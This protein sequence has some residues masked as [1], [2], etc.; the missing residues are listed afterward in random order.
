VPDA[1]PT[2]PGDSAGEFPARVMSSDDI[3]PGKGYLTD[4]AIGWLTYLDRKT[5]FDDS[6]FKD[7]SVHPSWDN[8]T[9]APIGVYHRYDL[10]YATY[11][12]GLMAENTP[13]WR[14]EYGKVLGYM[15]DRFLE[16]WAMWDW[17]ENSGPDPNRAN[18]PAEA[19]VLFPPGYMG[20]YDIPGWAGNGIEPYQYDPDPVRG[21]GACNLMY[22]G[23]LNLVIS[24]FNYVT[25]DSKYDTDFKV[26]YDKDTV[27]TYNHRSLNE[28]IA[29][30][31]RAN[32]TGLGCE[33][34]KIYPWCNNLTG[35]ASRFYDVMHGTNMSS[36]YE[37]WKRWYRENAM[38]P[39]YG[40]EPVDKH[41][42]Y[43]DPTIN[44]E[45]QG[46]AFPDATGYV[47]NGEEHQFAYN[48]W[49]NAY[50]L[51]GLDRELGERVFK[52]A[53]KKFIE[54]QKDGSAFS[55]GLPGLAGD[56]QYATICATSAAQEYGD[57]ELFE[58]LNL[59]IQNNY[60]PTWDAPRGEFFFHLGLGEDW[61]RG[62]LNDW[63]LPAYT[64]TKPGQF[65]NM[66]SNPNTEKFRLP[67]LVGVDFPTLR[68]RQA[69]SDANA[70]Y[71][72]FTSV[73]RAKLGEPTSYKVTKLTP[74]AKYQVAVSGAPVT[75]TNADAKGEI[76]VKA[77]IGTHTTIVRRIG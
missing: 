64:A 75:E 61:P 46:L 63:L 43:W 57:T 23:Y 7:D 14:E 18:Y 69:T 4:E 39:S 71:G 74:G 59:H 66:F 20:K 60:E 31:L 45:E 49:A 12:L 42:L 28:L 27:Y 47:M 36:A 58:G 6:W 16:Y 26:A 77:K 52:G 35:M 3:I 56:Y 72:A 76:S 1:A 19:A 34:M 70:F 15:A 17:I 50:H 33:V 38:S 22:K 11:A 55:I 51:S 5:T 13:A 62:Q 30:Q 2:L 73:D 9:G 25:G 41:A 48:W 10:S 32:I 29:N 54:F 65:G 37:G 44:V 40:T 24:F 21:N 53:K 68:V 8:M 67:T